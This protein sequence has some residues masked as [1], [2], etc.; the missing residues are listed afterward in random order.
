MRKVP[1]N[2][3]GQFCGKERWMDSKIKKKFFKDEWFHS[4][5]RELKWGFLFMLAQTD[6]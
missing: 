3:T 2:G 1:D 6:I 4:D 5:I